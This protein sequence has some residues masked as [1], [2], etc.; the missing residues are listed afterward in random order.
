MDKICDVNELYDEKQTFGEKASDWATSK[1]D[2]WR[3]IFVQSC[4]LSNMGLFEY[5]R[6]D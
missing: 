4:D 3:F 5:I 2:S 6:M 1:I